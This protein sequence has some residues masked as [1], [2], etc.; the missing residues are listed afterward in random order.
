LIHQPLLRTVG[1]RNEIFTRPQQ[2]DTNFI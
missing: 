2:G 1:S